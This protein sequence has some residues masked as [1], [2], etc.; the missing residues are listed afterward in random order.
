MH[1]SALAFLRERVAGLEEEELFESA[2]KSFT[3]R[4]LVGM[5]T[6]GII[7]TS[8][9]V[10]ASATLA[11]GLGEPN[12]PGMGEQRRIADVKELIRA[13]VKEVWRREKRGDLKA[14]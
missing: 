4:A 2:M 3:H 11:G 12:A 5:G 8:G 13:D 14:V 6:D 7:G 9:T 1:E 10:N